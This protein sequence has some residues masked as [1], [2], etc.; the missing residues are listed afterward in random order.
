VIEL[1]RWLANRC[2]GRRD[3]RALDERLHQIEVQLVKLKLQVG[4][5][6]QEVIATE[7]NEV[8]SHFR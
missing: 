3:R 5:L 8:R 6:E 2:S 1:L 4:E 7:L